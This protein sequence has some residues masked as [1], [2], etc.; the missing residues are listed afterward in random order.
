M[1]TKKIIILE[2]PDASGKDSLAEHIRMMVNGKCHIIHSNFDKELPKKNHRRQHKLIAKFVSKQFSKKYYTGND[3]VILNRCYISDMTYGQ[4][5]YGS[6]GTIED[7]YNYLGE[8]FDILTKNKDVEVTVVYCRPSK[9]AY[10]P[11]ARDEL[12]NSNENNKMIGIYDSIMNSIEFAELL[13]Y[14]NIKYYDYNFNEDPNY[15][16]IDR[17]FKEYK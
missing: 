15:I 8:F 10:N 4:L 13:C 5:G 17:A 3:T 1:K 7:K 16:F 6:K 12:L 2:G 9:S 11:I 14:Y